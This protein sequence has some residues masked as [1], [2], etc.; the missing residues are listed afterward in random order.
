MTIVANVDDPVLETVLS[1]EGFVRGYSKPSNPT[2]DP[3]PIPR[4]SDLSAY[5]DEEV[6]PKSI[7]KTPSRTQ[8]ESQVVS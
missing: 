3:K 7:L 6:K 5:L 1:K 8:L 4:E 2:K